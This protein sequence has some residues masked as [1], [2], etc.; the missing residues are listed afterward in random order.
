MTIVVFT[1]ARRDLIERTV[2]SI[3]GIRN[4][5][6]VH[7]YTATA[8]TWRDMVLGYGETDLKQL[9]LAGGRDRARVRRRF[10]RTC[11]SSSRP[12]CFNLTE[13]D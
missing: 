13:P 6:V 2:A 5:V 11:G 12:K 1:L 4:P 9:I 7:M 3:R 8:P 10:C